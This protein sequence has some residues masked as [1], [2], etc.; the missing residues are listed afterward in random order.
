VRFDFEPTYFWEQMILHEG[1]VGS[2]GDVS[3][4]PDEDG[5]QV[6]SAVELQRHL[7]LDRAR[8][9]DALSAALLLYLADE[10]AGRRGILDG[11]AADATISALGARAPDDDTAS[12]SAAARADLS[13]E[14]RSIHALLGAVPDQVNRRLPAA[15]AHLGRLQPTLVEIR[16]KQAILRS[17]GLRAAAPADA[18]LT[19]EDLLAWYQRRF[20]PI[21]DSPEAHA[22]DLGF[23]SV[24]DFVAEA[25]LEYLSE[26]AAAASHK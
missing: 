19:L 10:Q 4:R 25:V 24:E 2:S 3:A 12:L 22:L 15:L 7:R 17:L 9:R 16:R 20:G 21:G 11:G 14:Q 23:G 13:R 1:E 5:G 8:A 26:R 18:G 6:V